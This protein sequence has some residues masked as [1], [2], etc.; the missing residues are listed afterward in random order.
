VHEAQ[1]LVK[2]WKDAGGVCP[3]GVTDTDLW[4]ARAIQESAVHP[5]TG[6]LIHPVFRCVL[7][8]F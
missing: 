2:R 7:S 4:H 5:D 6:E 3:P 8:R 1:S